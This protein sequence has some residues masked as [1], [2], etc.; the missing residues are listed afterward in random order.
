M[1]L[2]VGILLFCL[3][4]LPISFGFSAEI[5]KWT[6]KSGKIIFSDTPPPPGVEGEIKKFEEPQS[7]EKP[8]PKAVVPQAR[9]DTPL[10]PVTGAAIQKPQVDPALKGKPKAPADSP[11]PIAAPR[12]KRPYESINVIMY[13]T[14]W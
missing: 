6:D 14:V 10:P 1:K 5:Y 9:P 3:L 8:K 12:E 7:R 11:Q 2:A 13:M 4:L